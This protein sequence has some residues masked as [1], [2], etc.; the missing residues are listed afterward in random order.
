M[1]V[2]RTPLAN[3]NV[4]L[5]PV[6]ALLKIY[7]VVPS[8]LTSKTVS[9]DAVGIS[10]TEE[11]TTILPLNCENI[12]TVNPLFGVIDAVTEPLPIFERSKSGIADTGIS[13]NNLPLPEN[14]PVYISMF[15]LTKSEPVN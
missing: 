13:L 3:V 8:F 4:G 2:Y 10:N 6:T 7:A 11:D 12:F 9:N 14:E 1:N 15:P 5:E